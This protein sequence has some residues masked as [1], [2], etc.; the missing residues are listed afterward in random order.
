MLFTIANSRTDVIELSLDGS[1][2]RRVPV[3]GVADSEAI[4][5]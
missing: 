5:C 1:V 3:A 4:E 2:V